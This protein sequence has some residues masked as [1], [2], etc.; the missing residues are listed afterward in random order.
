MKPNLLFLCHRIPYPPNK[1]DK[2]RVYHLLKYLADHY[3]I[4]LGTF[5]DDPSDWKYVG[6]VE[7]FCAKSC[8]IKL[9]PLSAKIKC[10]KGF[11]TG[12]PLTLPYYENHELQQWINSVVREHHI[13]KVLA[14]SAVMAQFL[15]DPSLGLNTKII[16]IVDIDS[17]KWQQYS[18][19]KMWPLS[20]VYRRE[21]RTLLSYE[22][23]VAD[24]FDI[25]FFVSSAEAE[26]FKKKALGLEHKITF[27]NNGVDSEYF[28]LLNICSSPYPKN[29][30]PIVFTGAMDYWPNIDA[31]N[32]FAK[33]VMP[34]LKKILPDICFYIVGSNP[35][36]Q[37]RQLQK[38]GEVDVIGRV[39]D[40]R[41]YIHH[42]MASV[43]PMRI[44]RGIQNKVLEAMAMEKTVVVSTMGLEG[45]NA[46]SGTEII[47]AD[48]VEE[49][50]KEINAIV[51][52]KYQSMGS[53]ARKR[54]QADFNWSETLP[55][56]KTLL[57]KDFGGNV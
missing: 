7:A 37:V 20:W 18:D 14:V 13:D 42:A 9:D 26:L 5:I 46:E 45:I 47:L 53:T 10:I 54:V 51:Q 52:G 4:Y 34:E 19:M 27:Y 31:V 39:E 48:S 3:T 40:I 24:F 28:T 30:L 25:S 50:V 55:I 41:P 29:I 57:E 49:Y 6:N 56:V 8:F 15:T 33:K 11:F 43:A 2:I 1:G 38:T 36:E 16:D 22:K 21:A 32:W 12:K 44:A 17:D 23:Q 35:S